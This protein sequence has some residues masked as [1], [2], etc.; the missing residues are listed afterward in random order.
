MNKKKIHSTSAEALHYNKPNISFSSSYIFLSGIYTVSP[1][2]F[3]IRLNFYLH[4]G[5]SFLHYFPDDIYRFQWQYPRRGRRDN[6]GNQQCISQK[7]VFAEFNG[8]AGD[9]K[10]RQRR[11]QN[12]IVR[13]N[14]VCITW[15]YT[16]VLACRSVHKSK[17]LE[18]FCAS[19]GMFR[20]RARHESN[21]SWITRCT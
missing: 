2:S 12:F 9:T 8:N 4:T 3:V 11:E 18:H 21:V 10:E 16:G 15:R 5:H 20:Q 19:I 1:F 17:V 14:I 6:A 13:K 7:M